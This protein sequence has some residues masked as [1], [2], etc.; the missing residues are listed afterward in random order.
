MISTPFVWN[1]N[2]PISEE[3]PSSHRSSFSNCST[4]IENSMVR[5]PMLKSQD[6]TNRCVYVN[7]VDHYIQVDFLTPV[8]D[9]HLSLFMDKRTKTKHRN[10][11]MPHILN[12]NQSFFCA[13]SH[14]FS[15]K[16]EAVRNERME[17][18]CYEIRRFFQLRAPLN[19]IHRLSTN[20]ST[21]S[22]GFNVILHDRDAIFEW[23][24]GIFSF[25]CT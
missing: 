9:S 17:T 21:P 4:P 10:E 13:Y 25:G 6:K 15:W 1:N 11:S 20:L 23:S 14:D 8:Y 3:I 18:D 16:I 22:I 24:N 12:D 2:G 19:D 7:E 5:I